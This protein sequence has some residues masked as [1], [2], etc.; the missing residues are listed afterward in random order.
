MKLE[1]LPYYPDPKV[2][3]PMRS[4][5]EIENTK[6]LQNITYTRQRATQF[7][8]TGRAHTTQLIDRIDPFYLRVGTIGSVVGLTLL[9]T[10]A[11][12][13][14]RKPLKMILYPV[15]TGGVTASLCFPNEASQIW[16]SVKEFIPDVE[17]PVPESVKSYVS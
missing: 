5:A 8:E 2:H 6:T 3:V 11:R 14:S 13:R 10:L 12:K 1:D 4:I 9:S 15:I 17:V 7:F 16:G